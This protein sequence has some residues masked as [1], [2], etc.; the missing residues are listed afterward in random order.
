M[1]V[2]G[3]NNMH[4]ASAVLVR[5]G[6]IVAAAEEERF[7]RKKHVS[8]FPVRAIRYCLEEA[9]AALQDVDYVGVSWKYWVLRSRIQQALKTLPASLTTFKAK[10]QRGLGQ[11]KHEWHELFIMRKLLDEAFGKGRY[12]LRYLDHHLCHAASA[13]YVSPFD[14][15]AILTVDGAGEEA[16]TVYALGE[17][18]SIK[19]LQQ[20][21]LPHSLG[22][23]YAA[24]TGFLGFK[25]QSDE[26]KV[27]GLA[28]Y[29]E[30]DLVSFFHENIVSLLDD[31]DFRIN[32]RL[33]DYHLARQGIFSPGLAKALGSP[34]RP[35]EPVTERHETV[36][37]STQKALE[38]AVFHLAEHLYRNTG[39]DRLCIAGGVG[40]NCVANGKLLKNSP[41]RSIF[42][43]PAS[44]DAGTAM[45]AALYLYHQHA[46]KPRGTVLQSAAL[47][48][49][50][51]DEA[52]KSALESRGLPYTEMDEE[53]FYPR[54]AGI[55]AD[56]NLVCWFNGRMEWGPRALGNRSFLADPRRD[57]M[58]EI[59]NRKIKQREP[60]RPFAPSV[61]EE[62]SP[63]YFDNPGPSPFML[64]TFNVRPEMRER[65]PAV[66]HVDGS[67]RPQTVNRETH[68]RYWR[69]IKAFD[70]LTGVPVVL[71][72]SLNVQEPIVCTPQETIDCFLKTKADYLVMNHLL[73][74]QPGG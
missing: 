56:G 12:Q 38:N 39:I 50:F 18:T 20:I 22:Q 64:F 63:L 72:T 8:G 26:Y 33:L 48:P 58:R 37:A 25:M 27:M 13:F 52:C 42:I 59:I 31:G 34:R 28:S 15:A 44:G 10:T 53:A 32:T 5:D 16:T 70:D 61:L 66:T 65:I 46:G 7:V 41:F 68:P 71:N 1:L 49:A 67:A 14:R 11:M 19:T 4:D 62:K 6:K 54:V 47:G 57:E 24:M 51:S 2:L 29:G 74:E 43:Q 17:G 60:F 30:P 73:V 3:I 55:L 23:F 9:G 45:G 69:L 36:A 40:F 35:D 21:Y